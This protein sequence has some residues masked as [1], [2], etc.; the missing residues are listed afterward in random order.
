[1]RVSN[2]PAIALYAGEG[3]A[4]VGRREGYYPA[5]TELAI[6]EDALVMRRP[7]VMPPAA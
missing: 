7:V 2:G 3:F 1:V 6:R 5:L 4:P